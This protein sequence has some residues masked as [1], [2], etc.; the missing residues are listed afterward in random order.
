VRTPAN[1]NP[2]PAGP[3]N[4]LTLWA[5]QGGDEILADYGAAYTLMEMLAGRYGTSF[6]TGLH[7]DDADGLASLRAQLRAAGAPATVRAVLR[8]WLATA[9]L[10]GV[11]DRGAAIDGRPAWRLQT[12]TLDATVNWD[13]S[14]A[15]DSPGA[16]PNGADFV[17]LRD[18]AGAYLGAGDLRSLAFQGDATLEPEPVEWTVD[19]DPPGHP[20][21]AALYSG[22]ESN[23]DRSIVRS[24]EVPPGSPTLTFQSQWNT[25][26]GRDFGFVQ[27]STDGGRTWTSLGN[28]DTTEEHDPGAIG[29]VADNV[30]GFTG[31]SAGWRA[32]TFDLSAYAGLNVLLAFRYV[33]D[34]NTNGAGWWIDDVA[35]AGTPVSDGRAL[36]G[37]QTMTQLVPVPVSGYSLQL[38]GYTSKTLGTP[39]ER[40]GGGANVAFV[41]TLRLAGGRATALGRTALRRLLGSDGRRADVVAALVMQNDPNE[42]STKYARYTLNVTGVRQPG[43]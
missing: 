16:P 2:R 24:V 7:R 25:Q 34:S 10:D 37:W 32:E 4:S 22:T 23:L 15:Y 21:N 13:A 30:P 18:R 19:P 17:R 41:H 29:L 38:L 28:G 26:E 35:V 11:L 39:E 14:D 20:G 12:G 27:V 43:G 40:R 33:S 9:A 8:D 3:E 1:P 42:R 31:D 36:G 6:M 5:D